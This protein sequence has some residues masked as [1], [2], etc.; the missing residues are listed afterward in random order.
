M[1]STKVSSRSCPTLAVTSRE[2]LDAWDLHLQRS[3]DL[4]RHRPELVHTNSDMKGSAVTRGE[5][6]V[7][8]Q[9]PTPR[10]IADSG[11]GV[12]GVGHQ[13]GAVGDQDRSGRGRGLGACP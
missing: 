10:S 2:L 9:T 6:G 3:A 1:T 4:R 11:V 7:A 13:T 8:L 5:P 12:S